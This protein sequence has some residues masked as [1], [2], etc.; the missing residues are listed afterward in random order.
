MKLFVC[1]LTAGLFAQTA[2]AQSYTI[3]GK[4]E[5]VKNDTVFLL[6]A[7]SGAASRDTLH[8]VAKNGVFTFKGKTAGTSMAS[9]IPTSLRARKSFNFY[10]EPGKIKLEG[11]TENLEY[12]RAN[13]T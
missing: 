13:G 8:T 3:S 2:S 12:V 6:V 1:C 9:L 11:N 4:L 5:G 10:L 7:K